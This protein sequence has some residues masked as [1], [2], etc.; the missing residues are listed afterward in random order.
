MN[1][2]NSILIANRAEIAVRVLT[3]CRSLGIRTVA[4]YSSH[5]EGLPHVFLADE[6]YPL[7]SG[8]LHDTYLNQ[9]KIIAIAQQAKV[10]AIHPG[11]GFLSE[12]A[13]FARKVTE[14]GLLFIGPPSRCI[15]S[16]GDK[17]ESIGLARRAGVPTVPGYSGDNQSPETLL[18]EASSIGYPVMI[19]A[20]AGGGGKGMRIVEKESDFLASLSQAQSEALHSFGDDRVLVEKYLVSPRHIEVQ[21]FSDTHNNHLHLFEREC[22]I[23]RRHQ[24][25]V[26]ETPST[27]L[28][29]ELRAHV[30]SCATALTREI[31][32]VN[33]G[34]VEFIMDQNGAIYFLEMNTRLQVE[35]PITEAITGLDLVKLQIEITEGKSIPFRQEDITARGHAIECRLYAEDPYKGHL[36]ASGEIKSMGIFSTDGILPLRNARLDSGYVAGNSISPFYDPMIAKVVTW[37]TTR[38]DAIAT[39]QEAL[40]RL[41]IDGVKNNGRYLQRILAHPAFAEGKTTTA[42]LTEHEKE[43]L[44]PPSDTFEQ[45]LAC[46]AYFLSTTGGYFG[47]EHS[48]M[49]SVTEPANSPEVSAWK[50]QVLPK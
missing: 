41:T 31:G 46:A 15:E 16:M 42:F 38:N 25:I 18:K 10:S 37:G 12:N 48:S 50:R 28:T 35:H 4:I 43:L 2:I 40:S 5:D 19:K 36:P 13:T 39:M 47:D 14:S 11:Y 22:S 32:Y 26:E 7:G 21:V 49:G 34:T 30:T 20:S 29:P 1:P 8:P 24:K 45:A 33:A 3:T 23:Q 9:D 44:A 17:I 6:A 27:A